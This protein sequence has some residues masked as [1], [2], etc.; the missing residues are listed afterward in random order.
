MVRCTPP[1]NF[2]DGGPCPACGAPSS[3]LV[4]TVTTPGNLISSS[5]N[6]VTQSAGPVYTRIK[7]GSLKV[8]GSAGLIFI[9]SKF[10]ITVGDK[11]DGSQEP[12]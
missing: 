7:A 9:W 2:G 6:F 4:E 8:N 12:R 3:D 5:D 10:T 1:D 11:S